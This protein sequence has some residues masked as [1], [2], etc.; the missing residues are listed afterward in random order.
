MY[1]LDQVNGRIVRRAKDGSVEAELPI[2]RPNAQD[3]AVAEDGT[4]AV[5]DRYGEEDVAL[6][7]ANGNPIGTL[8]LA[9]EGVESAGH[10]TG[11]FVDGSDVYVESEHGPLF[12]IGNTSGVAAEPREE[13]LGRPSRD[14][15]SWIKAGI[16]DAP[17]GRAYVVSNERPSGEHRFTREL[18]L[19]AP[20]W[21]ILLLDSDLSGTIYFAAEVEE[22][23]GGGNAVSLACLDGLTGAPLGTAVLPANTMPEESFRDFVVLDGGG[24]VYAARSEAGVTYQRY[25]CE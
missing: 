25:D 11:V 2:D 23:G 19:D 12:K 9:G 24:V 6:Y 16:T 1:V 5:L 15:K 18:R 10:V 14:G 17:A 4:V 7:D 8:P 20:I 21:A 22:E 3:I 13:V